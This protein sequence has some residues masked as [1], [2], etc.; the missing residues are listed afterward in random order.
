M[1]APLGPPGFQA[2]ASVVTLDIIL[3]SPAVVPGRFHQS[4]CYHHVID[5]VQDVY[6]K[7]HTLRIMSAIA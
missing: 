5:Y 3:K 4:N 6:E 7:I 1:L 2:P